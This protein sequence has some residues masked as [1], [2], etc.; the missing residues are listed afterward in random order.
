MEWWR[1]EAPVRSDTNIAPASVGKSWSHPGGGLWDAGREYWD[2][3]GA[4]H[5]VV[6]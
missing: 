4:L 5:D 3:H 6:I 1:G 2:A